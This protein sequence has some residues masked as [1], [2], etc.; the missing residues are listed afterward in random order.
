MESRIRGEFGVKSGEQM[1]P[2]PSRDYAARV[3]GIFKV[4]TAVGRA[5]LR[6]SGEDLYTRSG[7]IIRVG[8]G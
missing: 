2:L 8:Q 7:S 1:A 3:I 6:Q 5:M 4:V